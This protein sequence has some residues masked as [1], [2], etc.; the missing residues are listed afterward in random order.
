VVDSDDSEHNNRSFIISEI[1]STP[2]F[3]FHEEIMAVITL[4]FPDGSKREFPQNTTGL[5]VAK[6]ISAGLARE[7]L[8][9]EFNG[10][11]WD[12]SR[13][14]S[15][16]GSLKILKW[17]EGGG[18]LAYWHSSAH[19]MAEAVEALFPGTKF[20]IGPPIEQ[21]FYYDIDMGDHT[22]SPDDLLKVEEK[23]YELAKRDVPYRREQ[24]SW[25]DAV[26]YFE[27]KGD[28]YK[29]ELL[30]ELKGQTITFYHQGNFTDLCYGPHIPSTGRI[31]AI[32]LLS[33]AGAYWRGDVKRKM[34]QRIYGIAFPAKKELDEYL[35]RLEEAK[36]RDHRKLGKEL[37]LFIFHDVSP[38]AP[39]WLPKGMII[40][41]ELEKFLRQEL[42]RRGYE[43]IS[44]PIMVKKDLW[45]QSGHWSHYKE[46]MFCID[47]DET[48]YSLKPMN[49]PES[50]IVYRYKLRSYKDLP[51]RFSEIGRLH[52]NEISGAL[53][54]MFRVRQIT[55]DDAHIYCRPDQILSE[56]S[57]L[58]ELVTHF[59]SIFGL[60][61]SFNLSTKPDGGMG[62]PALW[63]QAE[64]NLRKALEDNNI[65][66][67]VKPKD[68]A[69]YGPKIDIQIEDAIGRD[70]QV[71]TIQLDYVLPE[72]FELEY[73]DDHGVRRRPVAIHRAIFGSFERFI[74]IIVEHFAGAFPTWLSPVQAVVLPI[75]DAF[76]EYAHEIFQTL[77]RAGIRVELDG[78]NEKIG[79]K[80]REWELK[81]V[82]YM[83]IVGEKEKRDRSVAVRQHRKGDL[84]T[85]PAEEFCRKI[86]N[87]IDQKLLT[88]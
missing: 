29:L 8:A 71:A 51:L 66:F 73:I 3:L 5:E 74:G 48:T 78:R 52:R 40:F 60:K 53:G 46:N 6:S 41:R 37:D 76:G 65:T 58:I 79:F 67:Q 7:A 88:L 39:F 26:A 23:M 62:D 44:T 72:R 50:T 59:Y 82:P 30:D 56:I 34:L 57:Q 20:G 2:I 81:K 15:C 80:I 28:P 45:E 75:T 70:W 16:D 19:L 21:G 24:K 17:D 85:V 1:G 4:T 11:V 49:C 31:K 18:K 9:M 86:K 63:E 22:L 87:E 35:F 83:L 10:E 47:S 13:P 69:F 68:G 38:G 14:L 84:G 77:S 64:M 54:G 32:K 12:L 43:E 33:V 55:M 25:E 42:D 61:P 36:R 27:A